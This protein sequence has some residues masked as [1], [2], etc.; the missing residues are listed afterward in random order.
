MR[1]HFP[2][3]LYIN[4]LRHSEYQQYSS[5]PAKF[6]ETIQ[7]FAENNDERLVIVDEVQKLPALLDEVHDLIEGDKSL[8]FILTGSSARKLKRGG[9][10][11]L[12]GRASR[13][14]FY[15]LC[16][17]EL[18]TA[19]IQKWKERLLHGALPSVVDSSDPMAD[20]QDYVGMYLREEV[21]A[22][23]LTRSIDNFSRFL[24]FA[25]LCNGEQINFASLGSDAQLSPSTVRSYFEILHDTLIGHYL[26][27][28]QGTEKRKA[29]ATAKFYLFDCGVVNA[30]LG[31]TS[32]AAG[33]PE[34]GK[35][36]EQ[37]LLGEIKSYLEYKKIPKKL[38]YWRSTS[39]FEVDFLV[40]SKLTDIVAIEV[41][42]SVNPSGKDFKGLFALEEDVKLTR[43]IV[44]CMA[45]TPRKTE[46]GVEILPLE[47][48]LKKLW[49]GQII[50]S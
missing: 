19:G 5:S 8:R 17:P 38:E 39:Q 35:L 33:T 31:R 14:F 28:F 42:G 48:F 26:P 37:A 1:Q 21:L 27:A 41:K 47:V 45:D 29:V 4:L 24:N 36:L 32:A 15:P 13:F 18:G 46:E 16:Y 11:L 12:G 9:A 7:Y 50:K 10:N 43:K 40:Y 44:V 3:A 30:L 49:D 6:R 25:A 2:K 22:E 20:L 23:G 34:Y